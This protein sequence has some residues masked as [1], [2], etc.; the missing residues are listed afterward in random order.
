MSLALVRQA[1]VEEA[2]PAEGE[3][4]EGEEEEKKRNLRRK[5]NLSPGFPT[6]H[7]YKHGGR[8]ITDNTG[9]LD[10]NFT[11]PAFSKPGLL[12]L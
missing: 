4:A 9:F 12:S 2:A 8:E 11:P 5:V 10:M 1:V 6:G 3:V 7:V